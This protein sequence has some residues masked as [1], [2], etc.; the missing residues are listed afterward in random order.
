LNR[1][2]LL[3]CLIA[4]ALLTLVGCGGGGTSGPSSFELSGLVEN[5]TNSGAPTPAAT[6]QVG[7]ASVVTATDGSFAIQAPAG[8]TFVLVIYTPPGGSPLTFRFDFAG[9][10]EDTNVGK[11]VVG[12]QQATVTGVVRNQQD[13]SL[14]GGATVTLGGVRATTGS[15]G[16]YILT[17]V[18][19]DPAAPATFLALE[20]RAGRTGYFPRIFFPDATPSS[21]AVTLADILLQPDSGSAPPGT[22]FNIE[23]F[24]NPSPDGVGATVELRLGGTLVRQVTTGANRKYG[25]WVTPGN[26]TVTATK[27]TLTSGPVPVNLTSPAETIRRD[28]TLL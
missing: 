20:G 16:V 27:G 6:V 12:P 24:V 14:L 2:R 10:T 7:S 5:I 28:V 13:N 25:F 18:A 15:N 21:G 19:H 17:G 1:L 3:L 8:T 23:G 11:L 9:I 4:F 26:Y 22:P